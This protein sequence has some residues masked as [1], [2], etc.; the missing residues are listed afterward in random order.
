M[1]SATPGHE[2]SELTRPESHPATH[3]GRHIDS[4]ALQTALTSCFLIPG[5][6]TM[7]GDRLWPACFNPFH[8][9]K[10]KSTALNLHCR[11][12][13][14]GA[15]WQGHRQLRGEQGGRHGEV[16]EMPEAL[17]EGSAELRRQWPSHDALQK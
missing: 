3:P 10:S 13:S 4:L 5:R 2:V 14:L 1:P 8:S 6:T 15:S 16:E 7:T 9:P 12:T 11:E 17:W